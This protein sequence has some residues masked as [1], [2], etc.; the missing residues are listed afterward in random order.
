MVKLRITITGLA[1]CL[2][3]LTFSQTLPLDSI[4]QTIGNNHPELKM[5]DLQIKASNAYA[6][7]AKAWEAPL[8]SA[9]WYMAPYKY[10][11]NMGSFMVSVQQMIPNPLKTKANEKY[12]LGMADIDA[13][14]KNF[15]FNQF[16]SEAKKSYYEWLILKKKQSLLS[17]NESLMNYVIQSA[18]NRYTYQK[19]KL[20]AIYK[21]KSELA[22]LKSMQL[23]N[24]NEIMQKRIQLNTLMNRPKNNV[25]DIDTNYVVKSYEQNR[26]DTAQID[27]SRSDL[28]AIDQSIRV[29][30]LKQSYEKSKANPDFGIRFDHASGFGTMINQYSLMAMVTI[31][32]VPWSSKMY[33]ANV[34]GLNYEVH[35]MQYQRQ[36]ALNEVSGTISGLQTQIRTQKSQVKLYEENLI[37]ALQKNYKTTLLAY[38][39]NTEELSM[40]L[41]AWQALKMAQL[42]HYNQLLELLLKQVEYETE[43]EIR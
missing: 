34:S 31:P 25:F 21:A 5:Y 35:A 22:Q 16:V 27:R 26:I 32:I 42:E 12:M 4:I 3:L 36:A 10:D 15:K 37:P 14:K 24:D 43:N 2:C 7:G 13:E 6:T 29:A 20:S 19:E 1:I 28:K 11:P 41:D 17:E 23:M 39:Q 8:V 33:K 9:G 18:Q 30:K 40:V 38:T